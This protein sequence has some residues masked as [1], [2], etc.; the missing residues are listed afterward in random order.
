MPSAP[1][2]SPRARSPRS[3]SRARKRRRE[4]FGAFLSIE[5]RDD[6]G[7]GGRG[8]PARRARASG[9][10]SRAFRSPSRTTSTSRAAPPR[11]ARGSSPA[12][13][14]PITRRASRGSFEAGAVVVGKTNCD[15]FGM[16]SSNENSA[17]G[18]VRNP[19]DP[20]RVPGGS[21]GG[22]A[23]SVAARAVP[24]AIGTDTG[25]S[26]RQPAALLRPRGLEADVRPRLALRPHRL[27]V[28][29]RSGGRS[30][31]VGGRGG[32]RVRRHGGRR[33]EGLDGARDARCRTSSR[34]S[35]RAPAGVRI[36]LLAEASSA[37]GGLH[38]GREGL[39][40]SRPRRRSAPRAPS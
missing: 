33:P 38:R 28:V 13:W 27:R 24:L 22:S 18:P 12:S 3:R 36:G 7:R 15:E 4:A 26:V 2:A 29:L 25:G 37:E 5:R 19:W 32:A 11:P 20:A 40:R 35:G 31:A 6:P 34:R 8:R 9:C 39:L 21:S 1:G 10:R 23:A 14:R 16:G 17:Y 30:D